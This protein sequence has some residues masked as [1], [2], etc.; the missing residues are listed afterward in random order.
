MVR[1]FK[2]PSGVIIKTDSKVHNKEYIA[3]CAKKFEE[4]K[5]VP[6]KVAKKKGDK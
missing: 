2:K 4:I 6:K 3:E 1:K 5:D